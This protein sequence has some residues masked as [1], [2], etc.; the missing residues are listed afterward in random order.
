M[1]VFLFLVTI[2][3]SVNKY[4]VKQIMLLKFKV[5]DLAHT[6]VY[7]GFQGKELLI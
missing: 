2:C 4:N 7:I 5:P 1:A 6:F 3:E